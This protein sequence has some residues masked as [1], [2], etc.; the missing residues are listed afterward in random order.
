MK[1][2]TKPVVPKGPYSIADDSRMSE[3]YILSDKVLVDSV[4]S[5][6]LAVARIADGMWTALAVVPGSGL[7]HVAPDQNS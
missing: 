1:S 2:P 3:D 7:V 5:N 6:P 4:S